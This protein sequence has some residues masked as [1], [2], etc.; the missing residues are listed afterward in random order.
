MQRKWTVN[1]G[2]WNV[3]GI[4]NKHQEVLSEITKNK[5]G[6]DI[7]SETNKKGNGCE[8]LKDFTHYYS[9]VEKSKR[10]RAGI[11]ILVRKG[12]KRHLKSC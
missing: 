12:L 7:L 8:D 10:A 2:I 5:V 9:W 6:S 4:R 3:Q 1:L 11:S